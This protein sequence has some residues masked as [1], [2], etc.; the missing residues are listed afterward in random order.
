MCF[1][2]Y[3]IIRLQYI[4][5]NDFIIY[6]IHFLSFAPSFICFVLLIE[7]I[8][9]HIVRNLMFVKIHSVIGLLQVAQR[10]EFILA[11]YRRKAKL[12]VSLLDYSC[13]RIQDYMNKLMKVSIFEENVDPI[14]AENVDLFLSH[15]SYL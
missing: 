7:S 5:F 14:F 13:L 6:Y 12:R 3:E 15:F 2:Y 1:L 4:M 11:K 10:N 8:F 9:G